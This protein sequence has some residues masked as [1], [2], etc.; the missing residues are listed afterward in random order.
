MYIYS[1]ETIKNSEIIGDK[2]LLT[3]LYEDEEKVTSLINKL[4]NRGFKA[5]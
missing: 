5:V 2:M 3:Y 1:R 4:D